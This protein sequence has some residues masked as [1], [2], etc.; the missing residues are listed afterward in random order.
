VRLAL[1]REKPLG[2]AMQRLG[3]QLPSADS[4]GTAA[5]STGTIA[6]P[7][8]DLPPLETAGVAPTVATFPSPTATPTRLVGLQGAY[9]GQVFELGADLVT[10]GREVGNTIVLDGETTVSRRHAQLMRQNGEL[11]VQDLGSTNGTF[12]NGQRISAPASLRAGDTVQ[13]GTAV[14]KVE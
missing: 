7:E 13:F 6:P 2:E 10:I 11:I 9:A 14:F 1:Q 3:V 12:V 8:P 4:G 5:S